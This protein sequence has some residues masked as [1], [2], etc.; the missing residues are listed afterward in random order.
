MAV[1]DF[2]FFFKQSIRG[3]WEGQKGN[4]LEYL[5]SISQILK[6][7]SLARWSEKGRIG[8]ALG[9]KQK[10]FFSLFIGWS[11]IIGRNLQ[12]LGL[13]KPK[14][15]RLGTGRD[16]TRCALVL[17]LFFKVLGFFL[18]CMWSGEM[19][20]QL[21]GTFL[22]LVLTSVIAKRS[23]IAAAELKSNP[24]TSVTAPKWS[25]GNQMRVGKVCL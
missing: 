21:Y 22:V 3:L 19:I 23:L 11:C 13:P 5:D 4:H 25:I 14:D 10:L 18:K 6:S 15:Y 16:R 2:E 7:F 9:K 1:V 24:I 17:V 12:K 20:L 8:F